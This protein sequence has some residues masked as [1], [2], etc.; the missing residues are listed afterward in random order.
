MTAHP[1]EQAA[2]REEI[3]K[4]IAGK[5]PVI[6]NARKRM[7]WGACVAI[8]VLSFAFLLFSQPQRAWGAYAINTIYWLGIA[9]GAVVL[10][11]AIRLANGRW[12]GPIMR[13]A[14]SLSAF[15][16]FGYLLMVILLIAGIW[17]YLPW[18]KHVEPR[19]APYLNVPF[20]YARTLIGLGLLWRTTSRPSS[21]RSTR[22]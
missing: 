3:L 2:L 22:S 15:L 4:D 7:I 11:C 9:Q 14:E 17:T 1:A 12:A 10:A 19:Q 8:G 16:P 5:L 6:P 21:S 20:L 18:V 13:I